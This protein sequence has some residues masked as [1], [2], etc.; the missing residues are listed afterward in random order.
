M[1]QH[2]HQHQHQ[3]TGRRRRHCRQQRAVPAR[4]SVGSATAA[5][6]A[7]LQQ[8]HEDAAVAE[9]LEI[10]S[11]GGLGVVVGGGFG[12]LAGRQHAV[13]LWLS[14]A[15]Q[16]SLALARLRNHA[17]QSSGR[18]SGGWGGSGLGQAGRAADD[19][20]P[21]RPSE[22]R[23][24]PS[25]WLGQLGLDSD[26]KGAA[27]QLGGGGGGSGA[28]ELGSGAGLR[29]PLNLSS[30]LQ[31]QLG[32]I[33]RGGGGGGG[34]GGLAGG[35]EGAPGSGAGRLSAPKPADR[36]TTL[37]RRRRWRW[38]QVSRRLGPEPAAGAAARIVRRRRR[39]HHRHR[40]R[41][42]HQVTSKE[43]E[44]GEEG[45]R[46]GGFGAGGGMGV[47]RGRRRSS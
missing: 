8:A 41:L 34:G 43:E 7:R 26:T 15:E 12:A 20:G 32:G 11:R 45:C 14:Q 44:E 42:R 16:A 13:S 23:R 2:Q 33:G 9:A 4:R 31:A 28:D 21:S 3:L 10:F 40:Q 19:D 36:A 17:L 35:G 37:R 47:P 22:A 38:K 30:Q 5:A 39:R 27:G 6:V 18:L 1:V 25:S 29:A 46:C 24:G